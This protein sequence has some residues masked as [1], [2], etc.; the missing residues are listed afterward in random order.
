[1]AGRPFLKAQFRMVDS[2]E[3]YAYTPQILNAQ[4]GLS[5]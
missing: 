4:Y 5:M 3:R 2:L 1:M